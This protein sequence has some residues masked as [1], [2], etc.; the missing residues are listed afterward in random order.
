MFSVRRSNLKSVEGRFYADVGHDDGM[1]TGAFSSVPTAPRAAAHTARTSATKA[2]TRST[3]RAGV[4]PV[5][6]QPCIAPKP[7]TGR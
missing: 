4:T 7:Y 1:P 3:R 2:R 6:T 5:S